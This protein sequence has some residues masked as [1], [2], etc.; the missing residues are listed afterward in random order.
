MSELEILQR[1][2]DRE[3]KSRKE[4]ERLLEEKSRELFLA[5]Q[6][7]SEVALF[8]EMSPFPLMRFDA[9]GMLIL[10]NPAAKHTLETEISVGKTVLN[11]LP[12]LKGID[13]GQLISENQFIEVQT[14]VGDQYF[15]LVLK[16]IAKYDYVNLYG[17]DITQRELAKEEIYNAHRETEALVSSISSILIGL[18]YKGRIT[19]LNEVAELTFDL[20][21]DEVLGR[22]LLSFNEICHIDNIEEILKDCQE[23]DSVLIDEMPYKRKDGKDGFL[24]VHVS[25]I[26]NSQNERTGYLILATDITQQKLLEGQLIQA[27]KLESLGQLAAGIAHEINTPIQFIG[28]NT[29]FLEVAFKRLDSVLDKSKELLKAFDE[30]NPL[31]LLIADVEQ[32]IVSSKLDYM[33]AEIPSAIEESL[34]GV[35]H[36]ATIVKAMKQ[37]SH[38]GTKEKSLTDINEAIDSTVNVAR[39]EWKYLAEL[40]CN[41]DP[42][43]PMV[44][45]LHSELNQVLL[46]MIVNAAHAIREKNG[47]SGSEPGKITITTRQDQDWVEILIS[48]NGIG[49][50]DKIKSKIFDPFFTTKEVGKGTGQGL[51]L[52]FNVIVDK[53]AGMINLETEV[54]K[55]STFIIRLPLSASEDT[56][57]V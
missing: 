2:F 46:N 42:S 51:S 15:Q 26:R 4:A 20:K 12:C 48:D 7:V 13:F 54:G 32:A 8:A 14:K 34:G 49:I 19:R 24:N 40:E 53:H 6:H 38:P 56:A 22:P 28:D 52:A 29:R 5:N 39:N 25:Q 55:G 18:D 31:D 3:R 33:R 30:G 37:F 57:T 21:L 16:G 43:L 50:P 9:N 11:A 45:C 17:T 41:L 47:E 36:V 23:N 27:Q 1:R 10:A 35:D 44:P